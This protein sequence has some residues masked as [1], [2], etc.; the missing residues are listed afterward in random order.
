MYRLD[1]KPGR[2]RKKKKTSSL[3][4]TKSALNI[5][6]AGLSGSNADM[7]TK[8]LEREPDRGIKGEV[9]SAECRRLKIMTANEMC[10]LI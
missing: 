6:P 10:H 8:R 1:G 4:T 9:I 3:V 7:E 2:Q 5:V